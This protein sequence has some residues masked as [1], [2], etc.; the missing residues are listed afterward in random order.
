MPARKKSR[1]LIVWLLQSVALILCWL[2]LLPC[3]SSVARTT[4]TQNVNNLTVGKVLAN[5]RKAINY[6]ELK[7]LKR[8]FVLEE[9]ETKSGQSSGRILTFGS[10][11][12][13][14]EDSIP[15]DGRP[16]GFDGKYAWQP[17]RTGFPTPVPQRL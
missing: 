4:R 3:S 9:Y 16:F 11:G 8:G 15:R 2:F 14:R 5:V 17:D 7:K 12:E 13:F 10:F 6:D 1:V